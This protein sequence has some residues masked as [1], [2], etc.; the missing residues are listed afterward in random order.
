MYLSDIITN[1]VIENLKINKQYL[2]YG[3]TGIGKTYWIKNIFTPHCIKNNKKVLILSHRTPLKMQTVRDIEDKMGKEAN[4]IITT[5]QN[6]KIK[7]IDLSY[8][9]YIVCDEAHYIVNDS[10]NDFTY[11]L[12]ED[13][14][15]SKSTVI[16]I[17][18]TPEVLLDM[19]D[20]VEVL[21]AQTD[22]DRSSYYKSKNI[23][24]VMCSNNSKIVL[25]KTKEN[26][27]GGKAMVV[28]NNKANAYNS[29]IILEESTFICSKYDKKYKNKNDVNELE[30]IEQN[31]KF[32]ARI[33]CTT[34]VIEAGVD[35]I[36]TEFNLIVLDGYFYKDDIEQIIGRKRF[37]TDED[38]L[39]IIVRIPSK[40][41]LLGKLRT[42]NKHLD[43]MNIALNQSVEDYLSTRGNKHMYIPEWIGATHE[44]KLFVDETKVVK[45]RREKK[46]IEDILETSYESQLA[47]LIAIKDNEIID[48]DKE[49]LQLNLLERF[50]D[51]RLFKEEQEHLKEILT[52]E[53]GL[54]AKDGGKSKIGLKTI[55]GFFEDNNITYFVTSKRV[56]KDGKLFTCWELVKY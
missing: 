15:K 44:G 49:E 41:S 22:K 8:F 10:W 3:G 45:Y 31:K 9:D 55:N 51:K 56:K 35:I 23:R 11:S 29:S 54:R 48:L 13:L 1:S 27:N 26:K 4:I 50:V 7:E 16:Y 18:A 28:F 21:F 20:D 53:Y 39:D 25:S 38:I 14:L 6:A 34:K 19:C 2:I 42:I 33:L 46:W 52:I 17:T 43:G 40:K 37:I 30:F 47:K 36:D 12:K 32:N 24:R 5:Y